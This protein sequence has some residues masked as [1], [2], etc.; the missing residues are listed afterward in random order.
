ML[1]FFHLFTLL[2]SDCLYFVMVMLKVLF[3]L[4]CRLFQSLAHM[5]KFI[6]VVVHRVKLDASKLCFICFA[7]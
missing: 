6:Q 4:V 2:A 1:M 3:Q 5:V 7:G